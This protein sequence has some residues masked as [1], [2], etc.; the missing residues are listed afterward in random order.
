MGVRGDLRMLETA[1]RRRWSIDTEK[2]AATVNSFLEDPDPR[3]AVRAAAIAVLMEAQNQKDEHKVIDVGIQQQ[4]ARLDA[5]AAELGVDQRLI[6]D[7]SRQAGI[8]TGRDEAEVEHI[9][10]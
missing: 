4:H 1:V 5:I 3:I 10:R 8:G 6:E 9:N 7:A 2:A